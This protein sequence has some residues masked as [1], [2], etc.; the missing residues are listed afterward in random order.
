MSMNGPEDFD[1]EKALTWL[2]ENEGERRFILAVMD[3][4]L[5][6]GDLIEVPTGKDDAFTC[7]RGTQGQ[8]PERGGAM[9]T[10]RLRELREAR[11]MTQGQ[12]ADKAGLHRVALNRLENGKTKPTLRTTA[13]LA[14]ALDVPIFDLGRAR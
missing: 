7:R 8:K 6:T 11:G 9:N 14:A 2:P 10:T 1:M 12:L 5:P 13:R 4:T 3:G